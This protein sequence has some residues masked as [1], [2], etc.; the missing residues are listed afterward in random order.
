LA[1]GFRTG[2]LVAPKDLTK[3]MSKYL[4]II[5]RQGDILMEQALGELI[6]DGIINRY[7][8][9]SLLEY[10]NRRDHTCNLIKKHFGKSVEFQLPSAGLAIWLE[11]KDKV[12]LLKFS[13][14]CQKRGVFIARNM[15]YQ[16][17]NTRAMRLGFGHL[18]PQ[19]MDKVIPILAEQYALEAKAPQGS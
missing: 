18:S 14:T 16:D 13:N 5:D 2:Y 15:L 11:F 3:E 1:P 17:R 9:K 8:R 6:E 19:E 4:G 7:L 12:N 10:E